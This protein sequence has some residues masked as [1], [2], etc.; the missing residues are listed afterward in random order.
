MNKLDKWIVWIKMLFTATT[1]VFG[2]LY[3]FS[4]TNWFKWWAVGI[5]SF[6]TLMELW[7]VIKSFMRS[8]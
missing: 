6:A 5:A 4:F 3:A 1:I 7:L 2:L 8:K